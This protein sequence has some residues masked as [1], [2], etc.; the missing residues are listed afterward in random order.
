MQTVQTRTR[1]AK[2]ALWF[3]IIGSVLEM[4]ST[5][6]IFAPRSSNEVGPAL[7]SIG[8]IV[9]TFGPFVLL[10]AL[11]LSSIHRLRAECQRAYNVSNAKQ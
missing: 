11:G 6:S 5:I 10:S 7:V 2:V 4:V 8:L 1:A 3:T 9:V